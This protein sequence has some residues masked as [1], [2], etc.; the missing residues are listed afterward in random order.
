MVNRIHQLSLIN[1]L[2]V[3]VSKLVRVL[4]GYKEICYGVAIGLSMW[5]L[6]T[7][8]HAIQRSRWSWGEFIRE[9]VASDGAQLLFRVLFVAVAVAF[10]FSL[11]RSNRRKR[12]IDNLRLAVD[13]LYGQIANPLLL[14][15]GYCQML[16]LKQGW[17][18]ERVTIEI[19]NEI[20]CNARQI[21]EVIKRLPPP[22][23]MIYEETLSQTEVA[24]FPVGVQGYHL[25]RLA[26]DNT[27]MTVAKKSNGSF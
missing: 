2:V 15:V 5:I 12:Q 23:A 24:E 17:P 7:L 18:V 20:H 8:M 22:G 9:L 10:G 13:S 27:E 16:S 26:Y 3:I 4:R 21:S 1:R 6:D 25:H 19:V 14:I 11:W